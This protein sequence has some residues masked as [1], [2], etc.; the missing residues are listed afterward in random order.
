MSQRQ[1]ARA[2]WLKTILETDSF[3]LTPA[4]EDASFRSYHRVSLP[5][6]SYILMDAPPEQ[7]D[8]NP[9]ID[10][11]GRL[12]ACDV[13]VPII[14]EQD[15]QQGFLL[16]SDLGNEQYLS[17]LD[18]TAA[19][20]LYK[21]AIDSLVRFQLSACTNGLP[22]Y[23]KTLLVNE[24]NLFPDWLLCRYLDIK[25]SNEEQQA[26]AEIFALLVD[27]AIQQPQVFVHRDYHSRNLMLDGDNPPGIVDY[28][29][30]VVGPLS[31]D[32]VSLLKDSYINWPPEQRQHWIDYYLEQLAHA[33]QGKR[34]EP[35]LFKRWFDLMGVQRELKVGGIFARLYLRDG[36]V[37]FLKDIPRTLAYITE[38]GDDYPE[39]VNLVNLLDKRVLPV[40]EQKLC[41]Q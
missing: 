40:L 37:G 27:N 32:L 17:R 19:D 2:E 4:S 29:D 12:L 38:L 24:M 33:D 34:P 26:L 23:D 41:G 9:F 5:D 1:Q 18:S 8:C 16:L 14:H 20:K 35:A 22:A 36:K 6:S 25:L 13:N 31:Y 11:T 15:L 10:I 30:A 21:A 3:R 28:Q 7:E 39:L